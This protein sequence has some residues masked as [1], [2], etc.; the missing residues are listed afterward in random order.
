MS[1]TIKNPEER[2]GMRIAGRAAA[3]V[4][5][6][7]APQVKAGITTDELDRIGHEFGVASGEWRGKAGGYGIQGRAGAFVVAVAG[8]Y[9]AIVGL[10]LYETVAMLE[11]RLAEYHRDPAAAAPWEE[12]K[13][14]LRAMARE[15]AT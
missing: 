7:I 11:S 4:L 13:K 12:V 3:S 9:P 15:D 10:P 1:V 2:E 14:R 5:T 8:S 6:M